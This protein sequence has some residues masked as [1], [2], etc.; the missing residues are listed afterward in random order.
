MEGSRTPNS[1][2]RGTR[3]GVLASALFRWVGHLASLIVW[4]S[5]TCSRVDGRCP[6]HLSRD[7]H[8]T[9]LVQ[10]FSYS[11]GKQAWI[12]WMM[13]THQAHLAFL[14]VSNPILRV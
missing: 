9:K 1:S 5:T 13:Y 2:S 3:R 8:N 7:W 14:I 11:A 4:P 6:P 12:H 10:C